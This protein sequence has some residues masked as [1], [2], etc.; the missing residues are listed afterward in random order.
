[1][2]S[3]L[4]LGEETQRP[5]GRQGSPPLD[6]LSYRS[7]NKDVCSSL[8]PQGNGLTTIPWVSLQNRK[9]FL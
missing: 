1:M 2:L 3:Q 9:V 6:G 8:L 7:R 4:Q 5:T